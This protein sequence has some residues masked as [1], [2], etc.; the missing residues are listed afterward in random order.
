MEKSKRY[1]YFDH[2][3]ARKNIYEL[4]KGLT[5]YIHKNKIQSI[6][7]IDK[8]ARPA[9]VGVDEY[10]KLNYPK[11]EKPNF[12]FLNPNSLRDSDISDSGNEQ[13]LNSAI[14]K[15]EELILSLVP[16]YQRLQKSYGSSLEDKKVEF[17]QTYSKLSQNKDKPVLLFDNCSHSGRTII[18]VKKLL[19]SLGYEVR[20]IT[21][22]YPDNLSGAAEKIDV[23]TTDFACYPFGSHSGVRDT[24]RLLSDRND[25]ADRE[26]AALLRAEIRRIIESKN[27]HK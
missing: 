5:E 14:R 10:W 1:E 27:G 18:S 24:D 19:E 6:I 15:L 20:Y 17:E 4:T 7:F 21:A 3:G 26:S 22:N 8:A 25:N 13:D 9:W 16:D 23:N 11:E 12:Y 2:Q